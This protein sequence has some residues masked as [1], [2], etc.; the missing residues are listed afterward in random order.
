MLEGDVVIPNHAE[1]VT[2]MVDVEPTLTTYGRM[3]W[4]T[5]TMTTTGLL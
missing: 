2:R 3:D 5:T 1:T 4:S